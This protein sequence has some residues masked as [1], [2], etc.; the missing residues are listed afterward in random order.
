[1]RELDSVLEFGHT[2]VLQS[3]EPIGKSSSSHFSFLICRFSVFERSHEANGSGLSDFFFERNHANR[4]MKRITVVPIMLV[5]GVEYVS[6]PTG[7]LPFVHEKMLIARNSK[8]KIAKTRYLP[9]LIRRFNNLPIVES[10]VIIS[11]AVF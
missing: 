6:P 10:F 2:Q 1:L 11:L 3:K 5:K 9:S 8:P 7:L 4:P